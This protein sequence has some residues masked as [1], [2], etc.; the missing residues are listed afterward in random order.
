MEYEALFKLSR[1]VGGQTA[2]DLIVFF[3]IMSSVRGQ[4]QLSRIFPFIGANFA[5]VNLLT[6]AF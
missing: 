5:E 1:W 2:L 3:L 6:A 4:R